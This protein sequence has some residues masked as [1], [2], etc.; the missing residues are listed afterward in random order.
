[1]DENNQ[2]QRPRPF[3]LCKNYINKFIAYSRIGPKNN[4]WPGGLK[5]LQVFKWYETV[6]T[7]NKPSIQILSRTLQH[8]KTN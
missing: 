2:P 1:M 8:K 7:N 3:L 5:V 6:E 4:K